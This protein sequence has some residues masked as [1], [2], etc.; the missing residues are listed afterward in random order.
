MISPNHIK[1][2]AVAKGSKSKKQAI[3]KKVTS[4]TLNATQQSTLNASEKSK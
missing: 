2:Q 1:S 3:D 4:Y